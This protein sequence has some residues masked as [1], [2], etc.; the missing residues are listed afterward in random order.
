MALLPFGFFA[1][2]LILS[3]HYNSSYRVFPTV[4]EAGNPDQIVIRI[5][6][7]V[8]PFRQRK[9]LFADESKSPFVDEKQ[10]QVAIQTVISI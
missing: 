8:Q 5:E 10:V 1:Y 3:V 2:Y 6:D 7:G 9:R 4:V